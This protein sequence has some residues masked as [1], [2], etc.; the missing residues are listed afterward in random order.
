MPP[1]TETSKCLRFKE[2][3]HIFELGHH[4]SCCWLCFSCVNS[5]AG[6]CH[7][8][9]PGFCSLSSLT[10]LFGYYFHAFSLLSIWW[11]C[12]RYLME[13]WSMIHLF[14]FYWVIL[15]DTEQ[16]WVGEIWVIALIASGSNSKESVCNE[17][18]LGMTPGSGRSCGEGNGT[19]LQ[20]SCLG[21]SMDRG[22]WWTTVHGVTK[23]QTRLSD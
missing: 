18:Y 7:L 5:L 8:I 10:S 22:A 15:L 3:W 2:L 11:E 9:I 21:N 4:F 6:T 14:W 17:G 13:S 12:R 23:S 19:P 16:M 20:D 1:N